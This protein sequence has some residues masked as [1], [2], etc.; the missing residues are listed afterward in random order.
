MTK[1]ETD[2]LSCLDGL[3]RPLGSK[4][5]LKPGFAE[6]AGFSGWYYMHG[7]QRVG[8]VAVEEIG[9]LIASGAVYA[10]TPVWREGMANWGVVS[11]TELAGY[12]NRPAPS[13]LSL[14]KPGSQPYGPGAGQPPYGPGAGQPPYGP[15]AG[16]PPHGPYPGQ[17]PYAAQA[18]GGL[19]E[20]I[21]H[22]CRNI[23]NFQGRASRA[24]Y[25]LTFLALILGVFAVGIFI[26]IAFGDSET[27][28]IAWQLIV[29]I[30]GL[31]LTLGLT[32]RRFHDVG[33]TGWLILVELVPLFGT[34]FA[35]VIAVMPSKP[36]NQY[37]YGPWRP[38]QPD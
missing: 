9:R 20:Y 23:F 35:F 15:G 13:P 37:G 29:T 19:I 8:P 17:D 2:R 32:V 18:S 4:K 22:A 36:P 12:L 6:S 34:I 10:N 5:G 38:G 11:G 14:D 25:W 1:F 3:C 27:V 30:G 31:I 24:E 33:L 21:K 16:Q 28:L 26:V 7:A